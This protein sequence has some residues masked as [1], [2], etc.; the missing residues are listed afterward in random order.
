MVGCFFIL[1]FLK[2]DRIVADNLYLLRK[3]YFLQWLLLQ[4][5]LRLK[6][7]VILNR[8]HAGLPLGDSKKAGSSNVGLDLSYVWEVA[9][10]FELSVTTGYIAYFFKKYPI[11]F[12]DVHYFS[13]QIQLVWFHWLQVLNIILMINS[14]LV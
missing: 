14:L 12:W 8:V 11:L 9:P 1:S 6:I 4:L 7:I 5:F 3:N 13:R 2:N 10:H